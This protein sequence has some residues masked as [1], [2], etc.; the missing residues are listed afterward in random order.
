[1]QIT[2]NVLLLKINEASA[3]YDKFSVE[4]TIGKIKPKYKLM[5]SSILEQY[6]FNVL[7][8]DMTACKKKLTIRIEKDDWLNRAKGYLEKCSFCDLT[9][10]DIMDK[11][12]LLKKIR[13]RNNLFLFVGKLCE[14]KY[15]ELKKL[16]KKVKY[17][18]YISR[19]TRNIVQNNLLGISNEKIKE[20]GIN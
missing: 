13:D 8:K 12:V 18:P 19:E 17:L 9:K 6:F 20:L 11:E 2:D 10:Y 14:S 16:S 4:E 15:N 5:R 1:M 3:Y 7:T